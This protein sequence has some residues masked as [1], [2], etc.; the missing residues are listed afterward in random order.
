MSESTYQDRLLRLYVRACEQRLG[1]DA[2]ST[3]AHVI[4]VEW[5]LVNEGRY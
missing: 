3:I 2:I 4:G 1:H 5:E